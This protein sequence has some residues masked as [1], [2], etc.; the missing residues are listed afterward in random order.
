MSPE[1]KYVLAPVFRW[2]GLGVLLG[3]LAFVADREMFLRHAQPVQGLVTATHTEPRACDNGGR[4]GRATAATCLAYIADIT[5]PH[6]ETGSLLL[7]VGHHAPSEFTQLHP[8]A[9][10]DVLVEA[11]A[12]HRVLRNAWGPLWGLPVALG[13]VGLALLAAWFVFSRPPPED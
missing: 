5:A 2:V 7:G 8:G 6:G 11:G 1:L 10:V 4:G 9:H 12:H 3:A 13:A